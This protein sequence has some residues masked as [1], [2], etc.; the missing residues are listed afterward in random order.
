MSNPTRAEA[1]ALGLAGVWC[2]IV[3]LLSDTARDFQVYLD[4]PG[5]GFYYSYITLP[6]WRL[7]A[8]LPLPAAWL[9]WNLANVAA[10]WIGGRLLKAPTVILLLSGQAFLFLSHGQ[11]TGVLVLGLGLLVWGVENQKA[12]AVGI[13]FTLLT[14]KPQY[15]LLAL[16]VFYHQRPAWGLLAKAAL[17]PSV[18]YTASL[19]TYPLWPLTWGQYLLDHPPT[20]FT[21]D[22]A[23]WQYS[24]PMVV[25]AWFVLLD[26]RLR[27]PAGVAALLALTLPYFPAYDLL[28]W[29]VLVGRRWV[30]VASVI[31][32]TY[33]LWWLWSLRA[34]ALMP[35]VFIFYEVLISEAGA[36]RFVL[37][38]GWRIEYAMTVTRVK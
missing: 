33:V 26:T 25:L 4:A 12:W 35:L 8:L 29:M 31:G 38:K 34:T 6:A 18:L 3:V 15:G 22:I 24:G 32:L 1:V 11:I 20:A 19:V 14:I 30:L 27:T 23:F 13:G 28:L 5:V 10:L 21:F 36:G 16:A 7:L 2:V 17:I 9:L 37:A